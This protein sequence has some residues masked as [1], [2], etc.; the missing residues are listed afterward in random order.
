MIPRR[1]DQGQRHHQAWVIDHSHAIKKM[2]KT[3][4]KCRTIEEGPS[5]TNDPI[6]KVFHSDYGI[7]ILHSYYL[8][9]VLSINYF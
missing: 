8:Y 1:Q 2:F 3:M 4:D 5:T 7:V 9:L 6:I